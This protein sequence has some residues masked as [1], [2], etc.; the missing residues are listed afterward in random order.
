MDR[1]GSN[2]YATNKRRIR[3]TGGTVLR[4]VRLENRVPLYEGYHRKSLQALVQDAYD[5][6][7]TRIEQRVSKLDILA[8]DRGFSRVMISEHLPYWHFLCVR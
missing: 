1:N 2:T 4:P 5:R 8:L 7:F 6:F 3:D